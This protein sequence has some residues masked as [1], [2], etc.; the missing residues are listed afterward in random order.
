MADFELN[1][2]K[3]VNWAIRNITA[4]EL[5]RIIEVGAPLVL[6]N[7]PDFPDFED[8]QDSDRLVL[9]KRNLAT[10]AIE[11]VADQDDRFTFD[12]V[13]EDTSIVTT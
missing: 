3:T 1:E 4:A 8:D 9:S 11:E 10:G 7:V 13:A 12:L 5:L 6:E 2:T